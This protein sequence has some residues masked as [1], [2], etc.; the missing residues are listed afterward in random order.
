M[1]AATAGASGGSDRGTPPGSVSQTHALS[2]SVVCVI[3]MSGAVSSSLSKTARKAAFAAVE[4]V[5]TR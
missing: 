3:D 5:C 2:L 1:S 4:K